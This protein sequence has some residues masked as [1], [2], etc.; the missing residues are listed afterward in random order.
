M[1]IVCVCVFFPFYYFVCFPF[2]LLI[3]NFGSLHHY[4]WERLCACSTRKYKWHKQERETELRRGCV[5][6]LASKV[7]H[8]YDVPIT[9]CMM[10][11]VD[12]CA[13]DNNEPGVIHKSTNQTTSMQLISNICAKQTN[14]QCTNK[15][16]ISS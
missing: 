5:R 14:P 15:W 7:F 9:Y 16:Q 13:N 8:I 10:C 11:V 4:E 2:A 3:N 6:F 12:S 1:C